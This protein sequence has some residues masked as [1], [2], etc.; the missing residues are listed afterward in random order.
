[1]ICFRC[2]DRMQYGYERRMHIWFCHGCY[3][4]EVFHAPRWLRMCS[5]LAGRLFVIDHKQPNNCVPNQR[6]TRCIYGRT[7]RPRTNAA[8]SWRQSREAA[9]S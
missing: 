8:T 6:I 7:M 3:R 4:Y 9:S 5:F 2:G 1:V